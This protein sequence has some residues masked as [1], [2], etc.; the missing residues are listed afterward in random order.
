MPGASYVQSS[1]LGGAWSK[2]YQGRYDLPAYRI[3]MAV[4][5]NWFPI[6]TG[7]LVRRGGTAFCGTTRGGNPGRV[8]AFD[9]AGANP[10]SLEFTDAFLRFRLGPAL[11]TTNDAQAIVAI[12]NAN[13]AVVQT[14]AVVTWTTGNTAIF[15]GLGT[16]NPLL[17]NR[18]FLLTK[19]DT[20]H[21]SL[22]DALTGAN[23]DGST[24][25]TFVSGT[26]SRVLE[27]ATNYGSGSWSTIRSIQ[28]ETETVLLNGS[29][30]QVLS[31]TAA[32]TS[33]S[34]PTFSIAPSNFL[35]GPYLDPFP[36][37]IVSYSAQSGNITLTFSFQ[38]YSSTTSY[39][40]GDYVELSGQGYQSLTAAN[41]GNTPASSPSNWLAV[42]GG[43]PVGPQ[44]FTGGDIG[45]HIR[46][47]SEPPAWA[48]GT[49][50]AALAVVSYNGAYY[51][52][53]TNSNVGNAP[54]TSPT[55]WSVVSGAAYAVWTWGRITAISGSGLISPGATIG[56]YTNLS[57]AFDSNN[58][59]GASASASATTSVTTYPS[60]GGNNSYS[61]GTGVYFSGNLYQCHQ[62]FTY[63]TSVQSSVNAGD[64][65]LVSGV[66]Y[67][68][69]A[70]VNSPNNVFP[71]NMPSSG[72]WTNLGSG[73]PTNTNVW[74]N[75]GAAPACKIDVFAGLDEHTSAK[76]IDHVT[77]YPSTDKGF[78]TNLPTTFT[79][80]LWA[81][82]SNPATPSAG[83]LLGSVTTGNTFSPTTITSND[84]VTTYNYAWVEMVATQNPPL[85]DNGSHTFTMTAYLSQATFYAANVN[86]GSVV[87]IQLVGP[88]LLYSTS[89]TVNTWRAGLYSNAAGWPTCGTYADGRLWLGGVV[90]NRFDASNADDI[91]NFAPTGPDGTVADSNAIAE[92]LNAP[93]VN[94][95]LWMVPDLQGV[96]MGTQKREWLVQPASISAGISP[97][98][99]TGNP[100]THLGSAFIEPKRTEHT[101]VFVQK[102]QRKILELF[103]DV[104]SGKFTA[105]NLLDKARQLTVAAIEEIAYQQELTPIIWARCG[106]GSWFGI[107]YK[108]DTLMTSQ[109]PTFYA[110]HQQLLG[111]GRIVESITVGPDP[112]GTLDALMMVTNDIST[113][114]RHV[115]LM[116]SYFEETSLQQSAWQLDDAVTPTSFTINNSSPSP[117]GGLTINGLWHLNG[118]TVQVFAG[119]LDCGLT[120]SGAISDFTVANGSITVPFGDSVS[121][122]SGEGLF[123]A[124]FVNSFSPVCPIVVG[125]AYNSDAQLLPPNAPQES[126]A[127]NG[128]AFGKKQ[129][130]HDYALQVINTQ[131]LQIGTSFTK[132]D[133][134]IWRDDTTDR[135]A[136]NVLFTGIQAATYDLNSDYGLGSQLCW[137]ASRVQPAMIA[138][139]GGFVDTSDH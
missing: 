24:L 13:P 131:G 113:G 47:F 89:V 70:Q 17:Q 117:Y 67:Q 106:D 8:I 73:N 83:T 21:F 88:A 79:L 56:N 7:A 44:G 111:S 71:P 41:E 34:Q 63:V 122:G 54:G 116:T 139:A 2:S 95:I 120:E 42:N 104:F 100:A 10:I 124:A 53:L 29:Q 90:D 51:Q 128:P 43:A 60:F 26:I 82:N 36:G 15:S 45:R 121:A 30:P 112:T 22:Q 20:T 52:S 84:N 6:E 125:F 35:D 48:S 118:K 137:R 102:H 86:N 12:S 77:L 59:K 75:L 133:P 16:N 55:N 38:A 32:P 129:R 65:W 31:L 96:L 74:T 25:G 33:I 135:Y 105:P 103:P 93:D 4:C 69:V 28:A 97:T 76:A 39:N 37:S 57:R 132:L 136:D 19:V 110:P 66:Y 87:T 46:L 27:L 72:F 64:V 49:T 68:A 98:N 108:R 101:L 78:G 94:P 80:N 61:S 126:G 50:Y 123:T 91:F 5:L 23:I 9:V 58:S 14:T 18:Q 85:A 119:G 81:S 11:V 109:G 3:S 1:F 40:V 99:I 115:E 114:V 92:P 138:A 127:R 130:H 62:T 134:I 107:T